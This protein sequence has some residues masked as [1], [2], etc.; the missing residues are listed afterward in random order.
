MRIQHYIHSMILG[1]TVAACG[2]SQIS[3]AKVSGVQAAVRAAEEVGAPK[4]PKAALHLE[5]AK[6]QTAEAKRLGDRDEG[7]AGNLVLER[8]QADAE[9][10]IQLA[11]TERE[12]QAAKTAWQKVQESRTKAATN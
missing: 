10:A 6:E 8:A 3:Q 7:E 9:L 11:Q 1:F 12:Q 5:L 4:I 2:G